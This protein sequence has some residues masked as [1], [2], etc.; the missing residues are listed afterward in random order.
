MFP[1]GDRG[2]VIPVNVSSMIC[3]NMMECNVGLSMSVAGILFFSI[4]SLIKSRVAKFPS[5][6]MNLSDS[7]CVMMFLQVMF[8]S[9][10]REIREGTEFL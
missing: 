6:V 8:A 9:N 5:C 4:K 7:Q 10:D 1:R 2:T 3:V